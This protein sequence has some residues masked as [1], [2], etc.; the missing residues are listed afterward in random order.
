MI[1]QGCRSPLVVVLILFSGAVVVAE[2]WPGWRGPTG[3]GYSHA[4]GL[5]L[6]WDGKKGTNILWKAQLHGGS[7]ANPDF[8]SPGWSCPIV[9]KD[10]IFL[11]TAIWTDKS[12]DNKERRKV[13]AEH[14]VLCLR[15]SDGE[16]L[17]DTTIPPG[18]VVV[19]GQYHGYAVPT[20]VTD[21]ERVYCLFDSCVLVAL[22]F[23]GKFL[24]REDVPHMRERDDAGIC[25][26]PILYEDT[27]IVPALQPGLRAYEKTTGK[28]KWVQ[29]TKSRNSLSTPVILTIGGK[30]QLIHY[31]NGVQGID[32]A[33]GATLWSC[34]APTSHA[35]PVYGGGL[36]YADSGRGG[37][38]GVAI[39]PTGSGDVSKTNVKWE[40]HVEGQA[41]SSAII[42]GDYIYR[43]T[44][45]DI[46]R[47]W[48]LATGEEV[49]ERKAVRLTPSTSPI[50]TPDGRIYFASSIKTYVLKAGPELEVLAVNDLNDGA[51][52]CSAAFSNGRIYIKGK[53]YLWCIGTKD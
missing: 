19:E 28:V 1:P 30:K 21:G 51:D 24:W 34:K 17:W 36:L 29:E 32:P 46:L 48:K 12:L 33:T 9:W 41:G 39:D 18:K 11:T 8:T 44:N 31:A 42:V 52:Y 35:S 20:P 49:G 45:P 43:G 27:V 6:T 14:H 5:P 4:K 22:D 13:V 16:Q 37:R 23:K 47:C 7:K 2:D 10:R 15:T 40:T 38:Q 53:S 26:S 25:S 50:A 3:M